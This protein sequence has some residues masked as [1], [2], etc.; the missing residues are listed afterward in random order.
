M[1]RRPLSPGA[2]TCGRLLGLALELP[3]AAYVMA[4]GH[5]PDWVRIWL[6]AWL[7]MWLLITVIAA[8]NQQP[9]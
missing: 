1:T 3:P 4:T 9:S 7:S 2:K 8:G 5:A 6:G